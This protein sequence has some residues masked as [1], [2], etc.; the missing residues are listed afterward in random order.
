[1]ALKD[2]LMTLE[3][4]KAV[5]D[6]DVA[7]NSAQFTELK[8]DLDSLTSDVMVSYTITEWERKGITTQGVISDS[9]TR[10]KT[11]SPIPEYVESI[12]AET[13]YKIGIWGFDGD[14]CMGYWSTVSFVKVHGTP[15]HDGTVDLTAIRAKQPTYTLWGIGVTD[16][17]SDTITLDDV[18]KFVFYGSKMD[19][20]TGDVE[21]LPAVDATL[22]TAGDSADALVTGRG[23]RQHQHELDY[24]MKPL[25]EPTDGYWTVGAYLSFTN[26]VP[27]QTNSYTYRN[28][29]KPLEH[30][31][32]LYI[33]DLDYAMGGFTYTV[34]GTTKTLAETIGLR[35]CIRI[36]KG[37]CFTISIKKM[38]LGNVDATVTADHTFAQKV[39][40]CGPNSAFFTMEPYF[41]SATIFD[42]IAI[43]GDSYGAG[44]GSAPTAQGKFSWGKTMGR[45][46][47]SQVDLFCQSG[48]GTTQWISNSS[49]GLAA[50]LNTDRYGLY[51]YG[52]GINDASKA[53][54][55]STCGTVDDLTTYAD[56]DYTT[57]DG[58][59]KTACLSTLYGRIGYIIRSIQKY[60][61]KSKIVIATVVGMF[62]CFEVDYPNYR[63][64][65]IVLENVAEFYGLPLIDY[66]TSFYYNTDIYRAHYTG[67]QVANHPLG[68]THS[69]MG[70]ENARLLQKAM[71]DNLEYFWDYI[72]TYEPDES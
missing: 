7:S 65:N 4:F 20:L 47:N 45:L 16:T 14:T 22:S 40:V 29:M 12:T 61:P 44:A 37:Y 41:V 18:D 19:K 34:S 64:I 56:I 72:G 60:A 51:W 52:H 59:E 43:M 23:L 17:T 2:K 68:I 6:V 71:I 38:I 28:M 1:M 27:S 63:A 55:A 53:V 46:I 35:R 30:D 58:D 21:A 67:Q 32:Y 13:G 5:R 62:G 57:P 10:I 26:F 25:D 15:Y 54:D 33:P 69:G 9:T 42:R 39:F 66:R 50:L 48:Q 36:P 31:V 49:T 8:A 3:D 11:I 70:A 24:G